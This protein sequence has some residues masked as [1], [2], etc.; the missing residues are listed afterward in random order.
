MAWHA[1]WKWARPILVL[2][3]PAAAVFGVLVAGAAISGPAS[4]DVHLSSL[5]RVRAQ[6]WYQAGDIALR[7]D[8]LYMCTDYLDA[9]WLCLDVQIR[10]DGTEPINGVRFSLPFEK[11]FLHL[12]T[13]G[14]A[15][16]TPSDAD[17]PDEVHYT[18]AE[19]A[20]DTWTNPGLTESLTLRW[21]LYGLDV[22]EFIGLPERVFIYSTRLVPL[23]DYP[24]SP[25][26]SLPRASAMVVMY[27][28]G[29][30]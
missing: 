19:D 16:G 15:D 22:S 7:M 2:L 3:T 23:P 24:E 17:P 5:E 10:N 14:Y 29:P 11:D 12:V 27:L 28:E 6:N 30:R 4:E 21:D 8:S 26:W 18:E 25:Y 1:R 13:F 20:W 9:P